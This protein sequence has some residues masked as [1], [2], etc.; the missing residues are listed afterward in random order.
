M[1]CPPDQLASTKNALK[2]AGFEADSSDIV[3][4]PI[5]KIDITEADYDK[6]F[7]F[8]QELEKLDDVE[9]IVHDAA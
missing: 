5:S 7:S 4:V 8:V 6:V 9:D 1:Y 2:D 3:F